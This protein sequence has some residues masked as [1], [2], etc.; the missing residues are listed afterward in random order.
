MWSFITMNLRERER[1][2]TCFIYIFIYMR[3]SYL[4][5]PFFPPTI[6]FYESNLSTKPTKIALCSMTLIH[7]SEHQLTEQ[8]L[9]EL[10]SPSNYHEKKQLW[11][12]Q[13]FRF[14]II[15]CWAKRSKSPCKHEITISDLQFDRFEHQVLCQNQYISLDLQ[16]VYV[17]LRNNTKIHFTIH[18]NQWLNE[19]V[20][21]KQ[22][23]DALF[24]MCY[25]YI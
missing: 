12:F 18:W 14:I 20:K 21:T 25:T 17:R 4:Y 2:R 23:Q 19:L 10:F 6:F 3:Q 24:K 22:Q 13:V 5:F 8:I 16:T 9:L 15:S 7:R 11:W 1:K